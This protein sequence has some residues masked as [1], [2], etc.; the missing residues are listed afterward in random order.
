MIEVDP[1]SKVLYLLNIY[2]TMDS[3]LY[4]CNVTVNHCQKS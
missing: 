4:S 3:V 2:Q 1:A